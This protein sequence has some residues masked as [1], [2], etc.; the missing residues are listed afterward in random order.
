MLVL[1]FDPGSR[2]TGFGVVRRVTPADVRLVDA[3]VIRLDPSAD[4]AARL[5]ELRRETDDLLAQTAPDAVALEALFAHPE[6][7]SAALVMAHARGVILERGRARVGD[8]LELP[9]AEVKKSLTGSGRAS[10]DQVARAVAAAMSLA[11]PPEPA[12]VSDALAVAWVAAGRLE[13]PRA[14][15]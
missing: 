5:V 2:I 6:H 8:V 13:P 14:P 3:G 7:P 10:K 4:L 15:A 9:P 1:G 12:D 11:A